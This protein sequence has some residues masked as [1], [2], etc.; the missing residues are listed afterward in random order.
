[1]MKSM[2][3]AAKPIYLVVILAFVGTII[4]AWGMEFSHRRDRNPNVIGKING[5]EIS[6]E[7][8]YRIYE[9]K[10]QELLKNN[11]DPSEADLE[12]VRN[13]AW[14]FIVS[15]TLLR[16]QIEKNKIILTDAE[17]AEYVKYVPP[18]EFYQI[19]EL[20][21]NG[22]FDYSKYQSYLQS[23]ASSQDPRA[24]QML[25]TIEQSVRSQIMVSKLQEL[26][27]SMAVISPAEVEQDYRERNEKVQ[28]KFIFL[29]GNNIDTTDITVSESEVK[30]RY[31]ETK[32]KEFKTDPSATLKYV[33]I[34]KT[35]SEN[36]ESAVKA[37][38][39]EI[40]RRAIA[41][42][43]FAALAMEYSQ[44]PGSGKNGGDLGWFGKGRMVKPFEEAAF[45]LKNI[46]DISAPVKSQFGWHIIKLTG[47]KTEKDQSGN[48]EDQIQASH[49]L[50]KVE[51][52]DATIALLREKAEDMRRQA[53]SKSLEEAAKSADLAISET[54]PFNR[55]Q[56]VPGIGQ[57]P[58]LVEFAFEAKPGS[59]SELIETKQAFII[60]SPGTRKPAGYRS[61]DE[62]KAQL[63]K[64]IKVEKMVD[65]AFAKAEKLYDELKSG[66]ATLQQISEREN[67]AI[68][69]TRPFAR[70]EFVDFVGSEPAFIGAAF[71]LSESNR[72][73][74][75]IKVR[76]GVYLLEFV[77]FTPAD[78]SKYAAMA[79]SLYREAVNKKRNETWQN[80]FRNLTNSAK[81]EDYRKDLG[82][83]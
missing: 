17:L 19:E 49:I 47:R 77:S 61:F 51:P 8:Y 29:S 57:N 25:V 44:D 68:K 70:H 52:S 37:E 32:E 2:R 15:Q 76:T 6:V 43:D 10:Y 24:E 9:S 65:K 42:E 74:R 64:T 79:D 18:Q 38:I 69:E 3:N 46:G 81:I 16:Q 39:D 5:E 22:Q 40:Y 58:G 14:Q 60:A 1:M 30:A 13:E 50:L 35:A 21:T 23:L 72:Y 28:V 33:M 12:K 73:S 63:E 34:N 4:F 66:K 20:Q 48:I 54:K 45:G 71:H 78:T 7:Q 36:D 55:G 31:E 11:S 56:Y 82:G 27:A 59:I 62:V 26:V 53:E 75:P 41:G 67:L 83:A 80:W